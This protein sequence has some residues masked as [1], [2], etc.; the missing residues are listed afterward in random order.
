MEL[1]ELFDGCFK[2]L[3]YKFCGGP[4]KT[5]GSYFTV[6]S[7]C[8]I[9]DRTIYPLLVPTDV[10][11]YF[12][13]EERTGEVDHLLFTEGP[14]VKV[15]CVSLRVFLVRECSSLIYDSLYVLVLADFRHPLFVCVRP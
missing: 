14:K 1:F 3:S 9:S 12:D 10:N 5:S 8:T 2:V 7:F 11:F 13:E 15:L 4:T 6:S